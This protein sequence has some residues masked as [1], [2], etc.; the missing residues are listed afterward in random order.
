MGGIAGPSFVLPGTWGLFF[1]A[2]ELWALFRAFFQ[3]KGFGLWLL[4]PLFVLW[5][6]VDESFLFG[7][8]VLVTSALGYVMDRGRM[9]ALLERPSEEGEG[10]LTEARKGEKGE[11][12]LTAARTPVGPMVPLVVS[13]LCG[14]VCLANPSTWHA[15]DV[16][17]S[18]FYWLFQN[19]FFN[20]G[21]EKKYQDN[22]YLLP[23]YYLVIVALGLGS[24]LLNVRRFSWARF[25]P[26]AVMAAV[27]G[28]IMHVNATFALVLAWVVA[29]NGQEWYQDRFGVAGRM[30]RRWTVWSTGGRMVTLALVFLLMSKDITGWGNPTPG[31][32]FGLGFQPD[33]FTLEAAD[34]LDRTNEISGN[35]LNT[36]TEQGDLLIWKSASKRKTYVDGRARLF[37][38]TLQEQLNRTRLAL[39]E[40][41]VAGW[42]PL[43]DKYQ[44]SA[45]M[46]EPPDSPKTY[47]KLMDSPN[48]I[49]FY[50]DGRIVMFGRADAPATDLAF[51]KANKLDADLLA[52]HTTHMVPGAERPPNPT[53]WID[54]VFQNR[55]FSRPQSRVLSSLRWLNSPMQEAA[56]ARERNEV[57][58]PDPAHCIMAIQEARKA[59]AHSPD[60]WV[61]FRRLKDA[62][63]YL[64][65]QENA[66]L[67]G[68]PITHENAARILRLQ[69]KVEL[70]MNRMQQR[71]AAL[72]YAIQTTPPPKSAADRVE[73]GGLNLELSELYFQIGARDMGATV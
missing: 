67:A 1:L 52:Y 46:I 26:F 57:W 41:D 71:A 7:L 18:P 35:I 15:F 28:A 23:T 24:F 31:I 51:F 53:S 29:P 13:V 48:W 17:A 72:N 54:G 59:L 66:M 6:N 5:A 3:G 11:G 45:I 34:F 56:K 38:R 33:A 4:L 14:L 50:D 9:D 70:L 42:K 32:Q 19:S 30:G 68:I 10:V 60:D 49:P 8:V 61:A 64:M 22:W 40:D 12:V 2:L 63:A 44:I 55:T 39:S 73:K 69:P 58:M 27:W 65:F 47:V 16:A 25:L 36:L 43:L 20:P 62:Y 37:P 21:L